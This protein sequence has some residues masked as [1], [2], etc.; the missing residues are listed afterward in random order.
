MTVY[1]TFMFAI[2]FASNRNY[3]VL[4]IKKIIHPIIIFY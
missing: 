3:T 1:E 4:L 2:G